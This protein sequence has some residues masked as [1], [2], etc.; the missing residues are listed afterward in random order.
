MKVYLATPI[1][2]VPIEAIEKLKALALSCV[3]E[4][5][6]YFLP[7]ERLEKHKEEGWP[8]AHQACVI[9]LMQ[10]AQSDV[11][12]I[13]LSDYESPGQIWEAGAAFA[14]NKIVLV[15]QATSGAHIP[16]M[17]LYTATEISPEA[18][19][20]SNVIQSV[21]SYRK[22]NWGKQKEDSNE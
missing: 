20:I 14:S 19:Y 12:V 8:N 7:L 13:V 21:Q 11:V 22:D 18:K 16:D 17:L 10:L 2:A 6:D 5:C 4:G 9:S 1:T 3:P 15:Y